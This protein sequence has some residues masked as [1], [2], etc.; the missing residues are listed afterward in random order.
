MNNFAASLFTSRGKSELNLGWL[1][2][3]VTSVLLVSYL[4]WSQYQSGLSQKLSTQL[5]TDVASVELWIAQQDHQLQAVSGSFIVQAYFKGAQGFGETENVQQNIDSQG[6]SKVYFYSKSGQFIGGSSSQAPIAAENIK[7]IIKELSRKQ[8]PLTLAFS[9]TQGLM[10]VK[11]VFNTKMPYELLGYMLVKAPL[12]AIETLLERSHFVYQNLGQQIVL[13]NTSLVT[14]KVAEETPVNLADKQYAALTLPR[15]FL[16]TN[17]QGVYVSAI[18]FASAALIFILGLITLVLRTKY[19]TT[20]NGV[21]L[22]KPT[23]KKVVERIVDSTQDLIVVTDHKYMIQAASPA[24]ARIFGHQP[25]A[26]VGKSIALLFAKGKV[27]SLES[28]QES[29]AIIDAQGATCDVNY[30][31]RLINSHSLFHRFEDESQKWQFEAAQKQNARARD[32]LEVSCAWQWELDHAGRVNYLSEHICTLL[33]KPLGALVETAFVDL[34]LFA[35]FTNE[36]KEIAAKIHDRQ[37]M[38]DMLYSIKDAAGN[39]RKYRINGKPT[40]DEQGNCLGFRGVALLHKEQDVYQQPTVETQQKAHDLISLHLQPIMPMDRSAPQLFEGFSQ[41]CT[42]NGREIKPASY[43]PIME[44]QGGLS[45]VDMQA[46]R[47]VF[48]QSLRAEGS[49]SINL[50]AESLSQPQFWAGVENLLKETGASANR[51][52][53]EISQI[54]S[55]QRF[56]ETKEFIRIANQKGFR[57]ALD[58]CT[59]ERA[60]HA[61]MRHCRIDY[62]KIDRSLVARL[63]NVSIRSQIASMTREGHAKGAAVIACGVENAKDFVYLDSIGVDLAQG[64]YLARP[65]SA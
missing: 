63:D 3:L 55:I 16:Q 30:T 19:S 8:L 52:V 65:R 26:L 15:W 23:W 17:W 36:Y 2:A 14:R 60:L 43:I 21:E 1:I 56:S 18:Y 34:T 37:E 22:M 20:G 49:Y 9:K 12:A 27:P 25:E 5:K 10:L 48:K 42:S 53:F 54:E 45:K 57:I 33:G 39:L 35:S 11:P 7:L 6:Y 59:E 4:L 29:V 64:Y 58:Q 28:D 38:T 32:F 41:L 46:L 62:V 51:I 44:R 47:R 40:F 61:F 13:Q 31:Q 24:I 50:S